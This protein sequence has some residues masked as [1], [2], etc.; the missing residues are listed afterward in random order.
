MTN[1]IKIEN[2][3]TEKKNAVWT[4]N[5]NT[6]VCSVTFPNGTRANYDLSSVVIGL[7]D[8]QKLI[9]MYGFKQ[10][11]ASN[12]AAEKLPKDKIASFDA[13]YEDIIAGNVIM[14]GEGKIGFSG[15]TRANA[16]PK[17]DDNVVLPKL[18]TLSSADCQ[19]LL[20]MVELGFMKFSEELLTQ[21]QEKATS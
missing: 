19:K 20:N 12:A 14:F 4:F 21:I 11:V 6:N 10:L 1:G 18:A 16:R 8:Q 15:R 2:K 13:D 5:N 9:Y 7:N 17:N 3:P